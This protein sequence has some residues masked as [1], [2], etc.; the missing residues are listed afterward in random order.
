ML[1]FQCWNSF[2]YNNAFG[3][4]PD[5]AKNFFGSAGSIGLGGNINQSMQQFWRDGRG[6]TTAG[7]VNTCGNGLYQF[8]F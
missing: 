2:G 3:F 7:D 6:F 4:D 8:L 5:R 1:R